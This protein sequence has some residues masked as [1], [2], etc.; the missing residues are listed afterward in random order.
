MNDGNCLNANVHLDIQDQHVF[1]IMLSTI[2]HK[3]KFEQESFA[4]IFS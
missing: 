3:S 1:C 4:T 2:D